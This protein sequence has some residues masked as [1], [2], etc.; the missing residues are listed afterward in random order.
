LDQLVQRIALYPDPLLAQILT[1]SSFSDQIP[2]AA[3]W[4]NQHAYLHDQALAAAINADQLPWDPSVLALLP[5]PNVLNMMA[6]D[7]GWTQALGNAV[8]SDRGAVMDSIQR[9]RSLAQ[10]YGYL[11]T[12][13]YDQVVGAYPYIQILPVNP[14]YIYVPVY[15]PAVVFVRPRPG[16]YVA[17]A[18]RFGPGITLGAGFMPFGWAGAGIG[19]REHAIILDNRPWVRT[20]QNRATYVHPYAHP[21]P[22]YTERREEHRE[23]R[24]EDRRGDR[25]ED[26][27]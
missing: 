14:G 23:V 19:W 3:A 22:H 10:Q 5:F 18:I 26:R 27:R 9:E 12:N 8:L 6:Q 7:P 16:F 11:R 25:R 24:R 4:A 1:A 20:W 21:L 15:N 13:S 17:G 2:Q